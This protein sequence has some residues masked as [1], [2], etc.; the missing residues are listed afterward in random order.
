MKSIRSKILVAMVT[1]VS[2]CMLAGGFVSIYFTYASTNSVVNQ[3]LQVM[4]QLA[5]E[6][7]NKELQRYESITQEVGSIARLSNADILMGKKR[8]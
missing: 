4:A 7:I 3:S 6:R 1:T 5:S 2:L 8:T